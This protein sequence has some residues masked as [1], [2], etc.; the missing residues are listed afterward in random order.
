MYIIYKFVDDFTNMV[1]Y[2][3]SRTFFGD[4]YKLVNG[5]INIKNIKIIS[6]IYKYYIYTCI[7]FRDTRDMSV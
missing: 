3:C 6:G 2:I 7:T 1:L 4:I 5:F